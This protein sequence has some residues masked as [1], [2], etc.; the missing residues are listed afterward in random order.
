MTSAAAA[1]WDSR[2]GND[3]AA[4]FY[5]G[6]EPNSFLVEHESRLPRGARVLCLAEGEGRNAVFL[7]SRGHAVTC[8]DL[9]PIGVAKTL[10]LA[11]RRGV[12]VA[13]SVGS[14]DGA[15]AASSPGGGGAVHVRSGGRDSASDTLQPMDMRSA[16]MAW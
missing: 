5:Y 9:S 4:A 3:P 15:S 7:A 2:Y 13:A 14:F 10:A 8:V 11:A 6:E 16:L 1:T 12:A